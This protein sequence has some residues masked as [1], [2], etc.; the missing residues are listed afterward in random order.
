MRRLIWLEALARCI[1]MLQASIRAHEW[2]VASDPGW[3]FHDP[4][5]PTP[6]EEFLFGRGMA[7][8]AAITFLTI[9]KEGFAAEGAVAG[10]L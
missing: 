2:A 1:D 7:Q 4:S 3:D 5:F 8:M 9:F 10:N 6:V